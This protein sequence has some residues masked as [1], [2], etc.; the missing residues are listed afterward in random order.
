[1]MIQAFINMFK[2]WDGRDRYLALS[3]L[4]FSAYTD[5][6]RGIVM[7][8]YCVP[9]I[10]LETLDTKSRVYILGG[11]GAGKRI[12]IGQVSGSGIF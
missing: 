12:N 8:T 3:D 2:I 9:G 11:R 7:S 5:V 1:M 6:L 4:S 10:A